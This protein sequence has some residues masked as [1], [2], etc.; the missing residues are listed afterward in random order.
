MKITRTIA[1][2]AEIIAM[3]KRLEI[4]TDKKEQ[5]KALEKAIEKIKYA[6]KN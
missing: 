3:I 1:L 2:T 5:I 4:T 6:R